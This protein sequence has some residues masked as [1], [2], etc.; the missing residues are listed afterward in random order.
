MRGS[1]TNLNIR[2]S[3]AGYDVGQPSLSRRGC[4]S[5]QGSPRQVQQR[6]VFDHT[7][8]NS[9]PVILSTSAR[10]QS[11]RGPFCPDY[12]RCASHSA[13]RRFRQSS[14]WRFPSGHPAS[15]APVRLRRGR[16]R[17]GHDD[18]GVVRFFPLPSECRKPVRTG[19][20]K[21]TCNSEPAPHCPRFPNRPFRD[22]RSARTAR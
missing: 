11:P 19:F 13:A 17:R 21:V 15:R 6:R 7:R 2:A 5:P 3:S 8:V 1:V 9:S 4:S 22:T 20:R 12:G 14:R 18:C 10:W 16:P